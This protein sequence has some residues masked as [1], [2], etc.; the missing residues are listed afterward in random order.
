MIELRTIIWI[1]VYIVLILLVYIGYGAGIAANDFPSK[2]DESTMTGI[3]VLF[4]LSLITFIITAG[5]HIADYSTIA[6]IFLI[7]SIFFDAV[8]GVLV[9]TVSSGGYSPTLGYIVISPIVYKLILFAFLNY[10]DCAYDFEGKLG[11]SRFGRKIS[12]RYESRFS[13]P[14]APSEFSRRR[15]Q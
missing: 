15:E 3:W 7:F 4:G 13:R 9:G 8:I 2:S 6:G 14:S 12:D 5:L 1:I 10:N 11:S